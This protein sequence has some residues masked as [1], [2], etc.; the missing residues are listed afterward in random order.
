M[1]E[2]VKINTSV[3]F[4]FWVVTLITN[5][6]IVKWHYFGFMFWVQGRCICLYHNSPSLHGS[7]SWCENPAR[8]QACLL[9]LTFRIWRINL[10]MACGPSGTTEKWCSWCSQVPILIEGPWCLSRK[11]VVSIQMASV[12]LCLTRTSI[13]LIKKGIVDCTTISV[14]GT[15][16]PI[17]LC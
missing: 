17:S 11:Y 13:V 1:G 5:I 16:W 12:K 2:V 15:F 9:Q 10:R 6:P 4:K 8:W 7:G 3:S 14:L